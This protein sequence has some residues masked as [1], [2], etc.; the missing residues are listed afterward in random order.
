VREER[1]RRRS[2]RSVRGARAERREDRGD[3]SALS[4]MHACARSILIF[5]TQCV[6]RQRR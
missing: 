1:G 3:H 4:C 6:N 5:S 2:A